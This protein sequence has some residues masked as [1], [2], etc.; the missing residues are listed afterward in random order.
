MLGTTVL[1]SFCFDLKRLL[2]SEMDSLLYPGRV[3][4]L[5]RLFPL[6]PS[7]YLPFTS[8]QFGAFL[9]CLK[10]TLT[11]PSLVPYLTPGR[12]AYTLPTC[13]LPHPQVSIYPFMA[14]GLVSTTVE[15]TP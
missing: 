14:L 8:L 3:G 11:V 12:T 4:L 7:P 6:T 10:H 2:S 9:L 1:L 15:E 5:V 13:E